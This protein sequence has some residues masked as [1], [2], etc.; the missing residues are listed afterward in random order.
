MTPVAPELERGADLCVVGRQIVGARH[1][2]ADDMAEMPILEWIGCGVT[3]IGR[4]WRGS[5]CGI[6]GCTLRED[7]RDVGN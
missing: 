7:L 2:V 4:R 6:I 3:R 5:L 1:L